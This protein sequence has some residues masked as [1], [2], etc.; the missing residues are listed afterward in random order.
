MRKRRRIE[1]VAG[2]LVEVYL[3]KRVWVRDRGRYPP[4]AG[5]FGHTLSDYLCQQASFV[6]PVRFS[7][8]LTD[9]NPHIG[10]LIPLRSL[11]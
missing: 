6:P 11:S 8:F 10:L 3:A 5:I 7:Q 1:T 9:R 2:N 4:A